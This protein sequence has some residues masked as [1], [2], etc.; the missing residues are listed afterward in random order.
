MKTLLIVLIAASTLATEA[1]AETVRFICTNDE[2]AP[3]RIEVNFD[4]KTALEFYENSD[5][6]GHPI[7][8]EDSTASAKISATSILWSD[9][10]DGTTYSLQ[11]AT[12]VL[13]KIFEGSPLYTKQCKQLPSGSDWK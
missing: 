5:V 1:N 9:T 10:L 13:Q 11:R 8:P 4:R 6:A 3:D 12:G 2:G 7:E